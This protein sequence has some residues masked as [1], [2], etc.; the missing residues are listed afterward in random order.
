MLS[1][2]G[3]DAP[4]PVACEQ[5]PSSLPSI[6]GAATFGAGELDDFRAVEDGAAMELVLGI[7]GGWMVMPRVRVDAAALGA[8]PG[9]CVR[10]TS[11]AV[12][13]DA[14]AVGMQQVI[15]LTYAGDQALSQPLY[16]LLS[17][18]LDAIE[19]RHASIQLDVEGPDARARA[20]ARVFLVNRE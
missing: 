2:C 13:E 8:S 3:P 12:I 18:D 9:S 10:G 14:P 7:Q 6:D 15:S 17:F 1:A 4:L 5:L 20:N 11:T 19:G 16:I